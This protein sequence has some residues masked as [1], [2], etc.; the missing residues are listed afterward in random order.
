MFLPVLTGPTAVGKTAVAL[1]LVTFFPNLVVISADSR[2][3]YRYMDIGTAKPT[4]EERSRV[5]HEFVDICNPDEPYS[6]GKFG[7]EARRN[8]AARKEQGAFPLVV[9]GSGLYIRALVD[10]LF[11]GEISDPDVRRRL[12]KEA[13]TKGL[14]SLYK[15][16]RKIDPDSASKIHPNDEQRI[17]RALELIELTGEPRSVFLRRNRQK[18]PYEPIFIGLTME[19]SALYRRIEARVDQMMA[20]G[21]VDEVERLRQMGFGP[22]QQALQTVGYREIFDFL[23]GRFPLEE[24]VRLIKR[25]TRRFAKRQLTWFRA[26]PRIRW[27]TL[28]D[29]TDLTRLAEEIARWIDT[30]L[31]KGG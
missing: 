5:P 23:E 1:E 4:A 22:E 13:E 26:D 17:L 18:S 9:G 20:R 27:F 10:G 7:K 24:A 16:L 14:D 28:D 31:E 2:Q 3:I 12:R 15:R 11:E 8:V 25:N 19:R 6:A 30:F 21:L 29:T